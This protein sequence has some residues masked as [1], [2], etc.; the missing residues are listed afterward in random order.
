MVSILPPRLRLPFFIGYNSRMPLDLRRVRALCF[1]VDGTLSDTDDY[2]V[3]RLALKL[4]LIPMLRNRR[5]IAR[6]LV[7]F[8][9]SPANFAMG[10]VDRLGLD[11]GLFNGLSW[12]YRRAPQ[13]A[14]RL[15]PTIAGVA[16]MLARLGANYPMAVVSARDERSTLAFLEASGL[17]H[18]FKVVVSA[19]TTPHSKPFPDPVLHA[20][21]ELDVPA[22]AC[23]MIGDTTVDILAGRR[24]GAQTVGV[25]CGFGERDELR[26]HGADLIL[27][28]T[29]DLTTV[30]RPA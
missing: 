12:L 15:P 27:P 24:A 2:Y 22:Q 23:L 28:S 5:R 10:I 18:H 8:S 25:L 20:A 11:E 9:E 19:L 17:G 16:D 21:R 13:P 7:M 29:A 3:D 1:D 14:H 4:R 30:L 26:R 6:R